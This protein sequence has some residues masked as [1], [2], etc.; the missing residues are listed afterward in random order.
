MPKRD[1]SDGAKDGMGR[2][3]EIIL[4]NRTEK[5]PPSRWD[6]LERFARVLSLIAIPVAVAIGGWWI[7]DAISQ[8][9]VTKDYVALAVSIL[10]KPDQEADPALRVWAVE[11]LN[12]NSS[13]KFDPETS[14]KLSKGELKLPVVPL[15]PFQPITALPET[16]PRRKVA[17][18]IGKLEADHQ[19]CTAWLVSPNHLITADYCVPDHPVSMT[20]IL[21]VSSLDTPGVR[22]E[23]ENAPVE[24]DPELGYAVLKTKG[25]PGDDYGHLSMSTS[26]PKLNEP[27]FLA[28]YGGGG[29]ESFS[30]SC[31]V[32]AIGPEGSEFAHDCDTT[33][34]VGGAPL[35]RLSDLAVIGLHY[36][37]AQEGKDRQ[38]RRLDAILAK[39]K[40]LKDLVSESHPH[41]SQPR[42]AGDAPGARP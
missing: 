11:L 37:G 31:R 33:G 9:S 19:V 42:A 32:I 10:A 4:V 5:G 15:A 20:F 34:G 26:G 14:S 12:A 23:V 3:R 17:R 39:S 30:P 2:P 38:A 1:M 16:D 13:V 22:Y 6:H 24:R 29:S 18:S 28:H 41:A 40:L 36:F 21:G 27:V 8:R 35:V 7:Q 25:N